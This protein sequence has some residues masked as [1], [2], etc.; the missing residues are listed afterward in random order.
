M[1]RP[2]RTPTVH[3]P[4]S[5]TE[6]EVSQPHCTGIWRKHCPPHRVLTVEE[7]D[8]IPQGPPRTLLGLRVFWLLFLS[9]FNPL[10][11]KHQGFQGSSQPCPHPSCSPHILAALFPSRPPALSDLWV[12]LM[13]PQASGK[14]QT[15]L[16]ASPS[17]ETV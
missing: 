8:S 3:R 6:Q 16:P 4:R 14:S 7:E 5:C 13:V 11:W 1:S 17:E 9:V 12:L 2:H 15:H 10:P